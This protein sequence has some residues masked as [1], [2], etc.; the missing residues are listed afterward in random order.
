MRFWLGGAVLGAALITAPA[1]AQQAPAPNPRAAASPAQRE[2]ATHAFLGLGVEPDKEAAARGAPLFQQNCSF[3]HGAQARGAEGPSLITS[4]V[5]LGDDHGEKLVPFLKVGRPDKGMPAFA[6]VPDASLKDISEFLHLQV[7]NVANRGTYK[8]LNIVQG[9]AAK[10]KAYVAANCMSCHTEATFT[11]IRSKFRS[12][13]LMQ[14][15]WVWPNRPADHSLDVTATVRTP[16][17]NTLSGR[18]G[19]VSD[20]KIVLIDADG[21]RQTI[22]RGPGVTVE[23]KDPLAP[24]QALLMTLKNDDMRNVTA[25]LDTLK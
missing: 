4:D 17:G 12:P 19:M 10:G 22:A 8:I 6:K 13:E 14:R 7:E 2:Q 18:V 5:V 20:F 1:V 3:C 16:D 23:L 11:G 9:D 25:Y 15:G 21:K 24:H